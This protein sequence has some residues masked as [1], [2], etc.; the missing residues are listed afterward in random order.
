MTLLGP[1]GTLAL[2]L[3]FLPPLTMDSLQV[4]FTHDLMM[5][6]SMRCGF[7]THFLGKREEPNPFFLPPKS[8]L[9]TKALSHFLLESQCHNWLIGA[10]LDQ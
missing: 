9:I 7:L 2:S 10:S 5:D 1:T 3:L 8:K 4:G 6:E